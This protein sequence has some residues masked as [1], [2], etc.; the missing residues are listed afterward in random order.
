MEKRTK[1]KIGLIVAM[2]LLLGITIYPCISNAKEN[3][4][5]LKEKITNVASEAKNKGKCFDRRTKKPTSGEAITRKERKERP[6]SGETMA[7]KEH[8]ERPI[9]GETVTRK[10]H[11]ERHQQVEKQWLEKN[12]KKN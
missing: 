10:E 1:K 9:S 8:K 2:V 5:D 6:I 12:V 11:K 3:T 7:R 4:E